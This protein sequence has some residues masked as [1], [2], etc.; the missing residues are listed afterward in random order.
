MSILTGVILLGCS[1]EDVQTPLVDSQKQEV[2]VTLE[3]Q[4]AEDAAFAELFQELDALN[5]YYTQSDLSSPQPF[6]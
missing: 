1:K 2:E 4:E 5:A 3:Q 6:L